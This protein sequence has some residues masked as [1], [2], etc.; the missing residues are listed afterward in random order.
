MCRCPKV[1]LQRRC[2]NVQP[3]QPLI[4]DVSSNPAESSLMCLYSSVLS[5]QFHY[6]ASL[7]P[8]VFQLDWTGCEA[9]VGTHQFIIALLEQVD[10]LD[11]VIVALRQLVQLLLSSSLHRHQNTC[12]TLD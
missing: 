5:S 8:S 4:W 12:S 7:L 11:Q 10:P 6:T 9:L 3:V 2:I 1:W